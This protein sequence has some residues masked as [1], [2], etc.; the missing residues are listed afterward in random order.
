[1]NREYDYD[2]ISFCPR[3]GRKAAEYGK[4]GIYSGDPHGMIECERC[5]N[6][7]KVYAVY[8]PGKYGVEDES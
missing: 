1:M 6:E 7:F 4:S 2:K 3:C 5:D 8:W